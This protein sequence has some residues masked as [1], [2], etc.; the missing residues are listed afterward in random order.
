MADGARRLFGTDG[1]RGVANRA[2]MDA[3]TA[4][5]LGQ[6]AGRF[7]NRGQHR[8]RVVIGKDTRLSGYM[9]EPALTAGF[10]GAGMDVVLVGPL[11]TPA[12]ALLTRSLRADLGVMVSASHN[13]YQDN[14]IKL[15]GPDGLKLSDAQEEAIEALMAGDLASALAAP[16]KLGRAS[17]LEDA[18]GRYIEAV[19]A[20]F[21]RGRSLEGLRIVVD[22]ANGA[23][24]KVAPTVLWELGAEVVPVGVAPDGFNI[25][26]G[27]GSTAPGA[28]ATLVRERRA[29]LGIALDGDADRLVLVDETG[30]VVDG[31]QIL[32]LIASSWAQQG[33]LR[34]GEVVATVMS[35]LGLERF[36]HRK[37]LKL[38]RTKVG[39]RYVGEAMR[40]RGCNLGGEQSGHVILSDHGTTG[41][42]LVAALQVLS[43]LVEEGRPASEVLRRFEPLPQKLVNV[44]HAGGTPLADPRVE[45]AIAAAEAE[46]GARGRVLIR[47]SGTEPLIRVMVEAEDDS[48]VDSLTERLAGVIRAAAASPAKVAAE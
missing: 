35:N 6:A 13:P 11:P 19:K 14:G 28:L 42:G 18:P 3:V 37:R 20:S 5:R 23:A 9:L 12:I 47:P 29:D 44:R 45:E 8:H 7:F 1:I 40:E 39:D 32:A 30:A 25:N 4:L 24:Y 34:G 38:H 15:F 10:V 17:R 46:L 36:L 33:R 16:A 21:P 41:D 27:C 26:D 48:L 43:V 22:C 2:P 31:D